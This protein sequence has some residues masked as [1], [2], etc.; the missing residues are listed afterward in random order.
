MGN[1]ESKNKSLLT[2]VDE[3]RIINK[4]DEL[5]KKIDPQSTTRDDLEKNFETNQLRSIKKAMSDRW[6]MLESNMQFKI[7]PQEWM[8]EL[9]KKSIDL[10]TCK[11]DEAFGKSK[12]ETQKGDEYIE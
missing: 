5:W 8:K 1:K 4:V 3:N 7:D 2:D 12:V 9:E 6:T 11:L 10:W